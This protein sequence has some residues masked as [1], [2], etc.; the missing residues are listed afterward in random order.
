MLPKIIF[1][2]VILFLAIMIL[3]PFDPTGPLGKLSEKPSNQTSQNQNTNSSSNNPV[4]FTHPIFKVEDI[5]WVSPLGESNG[6]YIEVQP[7]AG[8]T[9][10]IKKDIAEKGPIE[11]YAP[12][13]MQLVSYSH[14]LMEP[15]PTADWSFYFK[16]NDD[17]ELV[18]HHIKNANQKI[19]NV[20][21]NT[22]KKNDSRTT[23]IRWP[24]EI[25][26]KAGEV[27]GTTTGTSLAKNWNIYLY[28]KK[29]KNQFVN[30][31]RY[32]SNQIGQ[33]LI[34]A[35]CIF[36]YYQDEK[37]KQSFYALL[38]TTKPGETK[39]C[40]TSS[41]DKKGALSGLWH[42]KRNGI[43]FGS[44]D[45]DYA[46]PFSVYMRAD[47][48]VI[49]YEMNKKT[50][51]IYPNNPTYK[52]PEEI[53]D[54]HCYLLTDNWNPNEYKGYAY[55]KIDS[56]TQLSVFYSPSGTCPASFSQIQAKTYYR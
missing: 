32:E 39:N 2:L 19:V 17:L 14:T 29:V 7:L 27:I 46:D 54:S 30:Q 35:T 26:F 45:E 42:L 43:D 3:R 4:T 11:V 25:K 21:G 9:V 5:D 1:G 40:G 20:V 24:N 12:A 52:N 28:D 36:D 49:I 38:G 53:T 22:P 50:F 8:M 56:D 33:R 47:K 18:I 41:K 13:D 44:Y 37:L 23:D 34:N 51:V 48:S 55:F 31:K 6:G 10:N 16:I 15:E